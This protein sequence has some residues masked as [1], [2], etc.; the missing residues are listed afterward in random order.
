[1]FYFLARGKET[2]QAISHSDHFKEKGWW[3]KKGL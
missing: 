1:M 2:C 3:R